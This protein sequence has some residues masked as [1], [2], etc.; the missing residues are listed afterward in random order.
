MVMSYFVGQRR[1]PINYDLKSIFQ[2]TALFFVVYGLSLVNPIENSIAKMAC[3]TML[4]VV[5]VAYFIKKDL[6]LKSLPVI[7]KYFR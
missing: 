4:L 3:N 2:Y 5:F 1:N 6:P 7:G